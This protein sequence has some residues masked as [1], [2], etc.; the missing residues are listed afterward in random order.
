MIFV[1]ILWG[2]SKEDSSSTN[3]TTSGEIGQ[4]V[5]ESECLIDADCIV[6]FGP[7]YVCFLEE[8]YEPPETYNPTGDS[9]GTTT[10]GGNTTE[11]NGNQSSTSFRFSLSSLGSVNVEQGL[12]TQ[13]IITANLTGGD[14]KTVN[15]SATYS[16]ASEGIT[17]SF[18][19]ASCIPDQECSTT[20]TINASVSTP[21][22]TYE[23]SVIGKAGQGILSTTKFNLTVEEEA[24]DFSFTNTGDIELYEGLSDTFNDFTTATLTRG[25][26]AMIEFAISPGQ[27]EAELLNDY[28]IS[29]S[30]DPEI[31][32]VRASPP[33]LM[34]LTVSTDQGGIST[35]AGT[36]EVTI[37]GMG[38][39][40]IQETSF[41][42]TILDLIPTIFVTSSR[43]GM[44]NTLDMM[45]EGDSSADYWCQYIA[46]DS[47]YGN[48]DGTWK[49]WMSA[50]E[51]PSASARLTH[52]SDPYILPDG[53]IVADDWDD[54][55]DGTLQNPINIDE[56][57]EEVPTGEGYVV[58]TGTRPS[59][60]AYGGDTGR[61]CAQQAPSWTLG[62]GWYYGGDPHATE[63]N[64]TTKSYNDCHDS[65]CG[66][67]GC[68]GAQV[69]LYCLR[70]EE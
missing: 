10:N 4:V 28:G 42:L 56:S 25:D 59:G 21:L 69:R 38:G 49:A 5:E 55:V 70:Q 36:Y 19:P 13:N 68:S 44:G 17:F 8:C 9:G 43:L 52:N 48:M 51:G 32:T 62:Y 57:G 47:G 2:I 29:F 1:V 3:G 40:R 35:P 41:N 39:G 58:A 14:P 34:S 53:T 64:W 23:V 20:M 60:L 31:C 7:G 67:A 24:F 66:G 63:W 45:D 11:T 22:A 6:Q 18:D 50:F 37:T 33:C 16:P 61:F 65:T 15:F 26:P 46:T 30:F 27:R 54:L 12:S